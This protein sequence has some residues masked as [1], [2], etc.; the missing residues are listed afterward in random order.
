MNIWSAGMNR[1][2]SCWQEMYDAA[3]GFMEFGFASIMNWNRWK[4]CIAAVLLIYEKRGH[5][6]EL[7]PCSSSK[8]WILSISLSLRNWIAMDQDL[9][10]AMCTSKSAWY[11]SII[12]SSWFTWTHP[13]CHEHLPSFVCHFSFILIVHLIFYLFVFYVLWCLHAVTL[14]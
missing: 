6:T 7:M 9:H 4:C 10:C 11:R 12:P 14:L 3:C 2:R 1:D 8:V 13:R 5:C